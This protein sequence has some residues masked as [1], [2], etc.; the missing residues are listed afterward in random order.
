MMME[1]EFR[2]IK[3][4]KLSFLSTK[5]AAVSVSEQIV[6]VEWKCRKFDM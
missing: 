4:M 2:N 6:W 3:F 5:V 1:E